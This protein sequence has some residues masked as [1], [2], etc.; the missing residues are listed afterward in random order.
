MRRHLLTATLS[1][2]LLLSPTA[3]LAAPGTGSGGGAGGVT[4]GAIYVD[5]SLYRTV[6]TPTDLSGTGAPDAS[7]D[8]IYA[9]DIEGQPNVATAAPGDEDYNGGR[10]Q[11]HALGFSD[12]YEAAVAAVDA[13]G[14][15]D[16]D[17]F[18][19]VAAAIAG[20][21]AMDQGV[22]ASFVCPVIPARGPHS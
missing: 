7:F 17:S 9:I 10:W 14:S 21:H 1:A 13:N 2:T 11:V 6:L 4:G 3:A 8:T 12:S 22:I 19:E 5:G 15:G 20:G 18:D 16:L